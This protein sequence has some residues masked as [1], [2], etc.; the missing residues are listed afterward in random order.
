MNSQQKGNF[1]LSVP[2]CFIFRT[3][4]QISINF[5]T[6]GVHTESCQAN[7]ILV[8]ISPQE[9]PTIYETQIKFIDFL[10]SGYHTKD[11]YIIK[12]KSP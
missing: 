12:Y 10:Q 6:G 1:C 3:V 2:S 5:S 8:C 11:M 9:N 7:L 4:V